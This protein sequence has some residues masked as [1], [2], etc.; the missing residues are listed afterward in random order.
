MERVCIFCSGRLCGLGEDSLKTPVDYVHFWQL[1]RPTSKT[2]ADLT[3]KIRKLDALVA[4][5]E[6]ELAAKSS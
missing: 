3:L 5:L 1:T 4:K 2:A 6:Q